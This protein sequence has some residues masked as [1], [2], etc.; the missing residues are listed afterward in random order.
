ML[1]PVPVSQPGAVAFPTV[2][3]GNYFFKEAA[4]IHHSAA[5]AVD[6]QLDQIKD[7]IRS[8]QMR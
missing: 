6:F 4:S 3:G 8:D 2:T 1:A 7:Q 5:T